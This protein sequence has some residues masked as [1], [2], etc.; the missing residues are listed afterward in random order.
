METDQGTNVQDQAANAEAG[1]EAKTETAAEVNARLLRESKENKAKYQAAQKELDALKKAEAEKQGEYKKL[2][3]TTESKYKEL[4]KKVM[5]QTIKAKVAE[6]AGKSGCVNAEALLKLGDPSLL[7]YDEENADVMG[8]DIFVEEAKKNHPYLFKAAQ[9]TNVNGTTPGGVTKVK[10]IGAADLAGMKK[11]ELEV[12]LRAGLSK[13]F[14][15][16]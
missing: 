6:A 4:Q 16:A 15:G 11:D 9:T 7:Q 8:V 14:G 5:R 3:E 10:Q 2:F 13:K 12:I 1:G